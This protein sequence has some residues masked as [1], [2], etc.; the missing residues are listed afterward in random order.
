MCTDE[1]RP[2][3]EVVHKKQTMFTEI[4]AFNLK[5]KKKKKKKKRKRKMKRKKKQERKKIKKLINFNIAKTFL[6]I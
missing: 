1:L 6:R 2:W 5:K 4:F 3:H